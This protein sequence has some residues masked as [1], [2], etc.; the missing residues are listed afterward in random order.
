MSNAGD[1]WDIGQN[2]GKPTPCVSTPTIVVPPQD[3][4]FPNGPKY[5]NG[6][7][8]ENPTSRVVMQFLAPPQVALFVTG[9][10]QDHIGHDVGKP[11]PHFAS[12]YL[13]YVSLE[14]NFPGMP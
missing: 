5:A 1:P 12:P 8:A 11:T 6:Y 3:I 7:E 4:H 13:A 9:Q 2:F 10:P 14:T